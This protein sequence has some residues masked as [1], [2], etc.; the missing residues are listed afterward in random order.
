MVVSAP[1]AAAPTACLAFSQGRA[2]IAVLGF[3][4]LGGREGMKDNPTA[5]IEA[6]RA[7]AA[8]FQRWQHTC[9]ISARKAVSMLHYALVFLVIA[10]LAALFG[11]TG[12]AVAA[13]GVA[14]ILFFLFLIFFL[15]SLVMH[16]GR[17][18]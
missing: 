6:A 3:A 11:F 18:A 17:R 1:I 2:L 13:S 16:V 15:V 12:I 14:K 10:L 9:L 4:R 8:K 7:V 5:A